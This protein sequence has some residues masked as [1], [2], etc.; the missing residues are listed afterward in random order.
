[1]IVL[2]N[3]T[4][5]NQKPNHDAA[6]LLMNDQPAQI[7]LTQQATLL[8][9]DWEDGTTTRFSAAALRVACSCT[10]CR[11]TAAKAGHA[12]QPAKPSPDLRITLIEP[13]GPNS[14][15]LQ[16]SDGHTRGIFPFP[17]LRSL[18]A[19]KAG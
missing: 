12:D 15:N 9:I 17:Y 13:M 14:I 7:R 3:I 4:K 8:E 1:M 19:E 18:S 5:T 2:L 11:S 10:L 6:R 16:F